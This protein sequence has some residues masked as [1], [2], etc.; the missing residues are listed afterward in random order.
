VLC[1]F[2]SPYRA[3]RGRARSLVPNGRFFEIYVECD[4]EECKR[5]DPKGLYRSA[6]DARI[7]DMTGVSAPYEPPTHPELVAQTEVEP[8]EV[9]AARVVQ[10][11]R[12]A[13]IIDERSNP[14]SP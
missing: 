5:R 11:L 14:A 1:A 2:V 9:L 7:T 8:A 4:V 10:L 6:A 13:G 12:D 3:D